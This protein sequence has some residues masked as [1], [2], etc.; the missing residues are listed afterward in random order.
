MLCVC[1]R[2]R[3][4][5]QNPAATEPSPV[6]APHGTALVKKPSFLESPLTGTEND[7]SPQVFDCSQL[8]PQMLHNRPRSHH[9]VVADF[10]TYIIHEHSQMILALYREVWG[11]LL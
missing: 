7:S 9:W 1:V 3:A 2:A 10:L 11:G 8:R 4:P 6:E 5:P